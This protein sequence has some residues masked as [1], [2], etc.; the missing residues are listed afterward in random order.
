MSMLA[1]IESHGFAVLRGLLPLDVARDLE[2]QAA[3]ALVREPDPAL[4]ALRLR[5]S[6][7]TASSIE[8]FSDWRDL[9]AA[10]FS[11]DVVEL[12]EQILGAAFRCVIPHSRVRRQFGNLSRPDH[13]LPHRWHSDRGVGYVP[14]RMLN[15]WIPLSPCG[16]D[17]PSLEFLPVPDPGDWPG[18]HDDAALTQRYGAARELVIAEPGDA[19]L[20]PSTTFHRTQT[21]PGL[22]ADRYSLDFRSIG[23]DVTPEVMAGCAVVQFP[24]AAS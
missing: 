11:P 19:V 18:E 23:A 7:R 24:Q 12:H 10:V 3:F 13:H 8:E 16:I 17:A 4:D 9:L 15:V 20:F 22:N 2:R 21:G 6:Q 14:G 5:N 1:D